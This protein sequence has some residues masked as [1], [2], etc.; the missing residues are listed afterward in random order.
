MSLGTVSIFPW[1]RS[2]NSN[3]GRYYSRGITSCFQSPSEM[4][5]VEG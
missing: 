2:Q 5:A 1:N 4:A 3:M